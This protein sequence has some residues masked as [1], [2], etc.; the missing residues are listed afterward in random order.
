MGDFGDYLGD[1]VYAVWRSGGDP[2]RV[3]NDACHDA[4]Y[5]G[6]E[7]DDYAAV[8]MR[9]ERARR[10]AYEEGEYAAAMERNFD[11]ELDQYPEYDDHLGDSTCPT[12]ITRGETPSKL[13]QN[14]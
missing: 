11:K 3:D 4:F 7:A 2:D 9:R 6:A 12:V 13:H 10:E 8:M 5:D 14:R 1:V